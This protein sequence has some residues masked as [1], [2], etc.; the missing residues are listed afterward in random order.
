[1]TI[2]H[3]YAAD[4]TKFERDADGALIVYGKATGPQLDLDAQICDPE[5]LKKAMP[6]WMEFGNIREMHGPIA[7]G[8]GIELEAKGDDWWLKSKCVDP[9]TARKIE[10]GVLKGYSIGIKGPKVVKDAAAPGGRIVGGIVAETSYVDRP[11]NPTA[12]LMI[13][14][15][16]G[17]GQLAPVDLDGEPIVQDQSKADDTADD[18]AGTVAGFDRDRAE[19]LLKAV[20]A[21]GT[22]DEQP[23]I[24]GAV[25]AIALIAGLIQAEAAELAAGCYGETWDISL[26]LRA[27]EV[28]KLFVE[29]ERA[30][31][32]SAATAGTVTADV[33][34][35]A[36]PDLTK[37]AGGGVTLEGLAATVD[38]LTELV[39]RAFSQ[40][41]RDDAADDGTAMPDGSFPIVNRAD[42]ENAIRS[43]GRAK[44]PAAARRHIIARARALEA[45]DLI[46]GDWTKAADPDTTT[47]TETPVSKDELAEL[48]ELVKNAVAEAT[49]PLEESLKT[50]DDRVKALEVELAKVKAQPI[51]G[52]PVITRTA[53]TTPPSGEADNKAAY[54]RHLAGQ[55]NDQAAKA[56][57]LK[58]AAEAER[59]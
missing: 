4:I 1:M 11:C 17:S 58:L 34:L 59:G 42:L 46:P 7:A 47:T 50:R 24:D 41:E 56:G 38:K 30:G 13:A 53:I 44:N 55:V 26:L 51:P 18:A 29:R 25:Q 37:T 5:W 28:L 12:T 8:V 35:A 45:A 52:G 21:D 19:R 27:V 32:T 33:D 57:Y 15:M 36:V 23:D 43:A 48:A 16:A 9:G 40:A 2:T 6:A 31:A 3:A 22:I 10:Q 14:K 49:K 20:S 39:K 54:Y